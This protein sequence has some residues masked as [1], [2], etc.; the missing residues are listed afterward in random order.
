MP[1]KMGA[2]HAV[3][4]LRGGNAYG[5]DKRLASDRSSYCIKM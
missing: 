1:K 5:N 2:D 4:R 3:Y